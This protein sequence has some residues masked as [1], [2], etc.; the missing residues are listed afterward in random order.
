MKKK[1][2]NLRT[3]LVIF[4]FI[5]TMIMGCSDNNPT[6]PKTDGYWKQFR[7]ND[8]Y[9]NFVTN[10]LS[11]DNTF[12]TTGMNGVTTFYD[13]ESYP[14]IKTMWY[15][16]A[17]YDNK[18]IITKDITAFFEKGDSR[19]VVFSNNSS[20]EDMSIA[21]LNPYSII[22]NLRHYKFLIT[23]GMR[24]FGA[25]NNN[26]RF[27]TIIEGRDSLNITSSYV[28]YA[29]IDLNNGIRISNSGFS[30]VPF[31]S[32]TMLFVSYI[33]SFNEKF[34]ISYTKFFDSSSNYLEISGNGEIK[35]YRN[36]FE[37]LQYIVSFFEYQGYLCAQKSDTQLIYTSDGENWQHMA[38]LDPYIFDF[39]EIGGYLFI[40]YKDKIYCLGDN[41]NDLRLYQIPTEEISGRSISSINKFKDDLVITTSNGIFYKSFIEIMNDKTLIRGIN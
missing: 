6:K 8:P 13:F 2:C 41:I 9:R 25:I 23:D 29:D 7:F 14:S 28:V 30:E 38:Y 12:Y 31:S 17:G 40:Y 5:M 24:E 19:M 39:K 36:H 20:D 33:K 1:K 22:N 32:R 15:M 3:K 10:G 21:N 34:Y 27:V 11:V 4:L 35:H 18:P 16:S 37:G 26:N